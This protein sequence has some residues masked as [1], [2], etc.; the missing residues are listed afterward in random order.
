MKILWFN[1]RDIRNPEAGGAEVLTHEVA[2]RL[3]KRNHEITL[4]TS[5]FNNALPYETVD[6]IVIIRQ[7]GKYS[8]YSKAKAYYKRH[9]ENHDIVIDEINVRP[10]L[11]PKYVDEK[12]ILALIFQV[13]SE[14]F[15]LE[16]PFPL[17]YLGHYY[18]EKKWLS[19]YTNIT[20]ITISNSTKEDLEKLDFKNVFVV[21]VGLSVNPLSDV[22]R[23]EPSPTI[24]FIGRLK[25]HKLPDHA[26]IAFSLVKKQIP[27][28]KMWI[29]GDGYMRKELERKFIIK[30]VTFYGRVNSELKYNLL[31]RISFSCSSGHKGRL[32]SSCDRIELDG[33]PCCCIQC[34]GIKRF[35]QKR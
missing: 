26:M 18:L 20:T 13:S 14:Q 2:S 30:D 12:P 27:D 19:H 16:L 31:S 17:S 29:I 8:V 35:S 11:T 7:G 5:S 1:W 3:V 4:F 25:R 28:A 34:P 9:K 33:N 32:G 6:G 23:K 22:P 10:F 24:V 21:P 15:L